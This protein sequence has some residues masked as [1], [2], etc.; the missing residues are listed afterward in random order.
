MKACF[1][2]VFKLKRLW[3]GNIP[4]KFKR[5]RGWLSLKIFSVINLTVKPWLVS[6]DNPLVPL[7]F[8]SFFFRSR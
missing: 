1:I 8:I 5:N 3:D 4:L 2:R 7:T 6:S